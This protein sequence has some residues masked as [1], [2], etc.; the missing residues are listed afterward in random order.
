[1]QKG[2]HLQSMGTA[3]RTASSLMSFEA[4]GHIVFIYLH[5]YSSLANFYVGFLSVYFPGFDE[6]Q[7]RNEHPHTLAFYHK[8][9]GSK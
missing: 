5:I 1:M 9:E 8:C 2:T 4:R 7:R 3:V 6:N